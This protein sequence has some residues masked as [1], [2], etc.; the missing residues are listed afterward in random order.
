MSVRIKL[1]IFVYMFR[2][3]PTDLSQLQNQ[4]AS[5]QTLWLSK[6]QSS[7]FPQSSPNLFPS[8]SWAYLITRASSASDGASRVH[9]SPDHASRAHARISSC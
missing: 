8:K 3:N 4:H 1:S 9:I 6:M 2:R 7:L 5:C